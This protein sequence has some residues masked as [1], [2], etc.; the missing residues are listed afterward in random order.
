MTVIQF[1]MGVCT[2]DVLQ[3]TVLRIWI[4]LVGHTQEFQ[5]FPLILAAHG[6]EVGSS[7]TPHND[8]TNPFS[9]RIFTFSCVYA[10]TDSKGS[11]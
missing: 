2:I 7:Q 10:L 4:M 6:A 9:G 5:C 3:I 1:H 11:C 8:G